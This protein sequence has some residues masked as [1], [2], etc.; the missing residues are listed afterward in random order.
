MKA[1]T[2]LQFTCGWCHQPAINTHPY[3]NFNHCPSCYWSKHVI[4]HTE[5]VRSG[6]D[7]MMRPV[8][9]LPGVRID[10]ECVKC[11]A[12]SSARDWPGMPDFRE[13]T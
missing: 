8:K 11:G 3:K 5:P 13:L 1:K 4:S 10:H 7:G 9:I 2:E 6:C 12:T